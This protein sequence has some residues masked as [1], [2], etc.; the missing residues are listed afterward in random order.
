MTTNHPFILSVTVKLTQQP[1]SSVTSHLGVSPE[2]G[3]WREG[4]SHSPGF[5]L[6]L[7]DIWE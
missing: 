3:G 1:Q 6:S 2:V 4:G 5:T 7:V